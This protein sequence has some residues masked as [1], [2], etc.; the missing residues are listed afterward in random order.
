MTRRISG[1]RRRRNNHLR[2]LSRHSSNP[3]TIQ[4][5]RHRRQHKGNPHRPSHGTLNNR[6]KSARPIKS[7]RNINITP[8]QRSN[9]GRR[10]IINDRRAA[11]APQESNQRRK[12]RITSTTGLNTP[13]L[14][15]HERTRRTHTRKKQRGKPQRRGHRPKQR[16]GSRSSLTYRITSQERSTFKRHHRRIRHKYTRP[17]THR[18]QGSSSNTRIPEHRLTQSS[19]N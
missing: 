16:R 3:R 9:K 7:R 11:R 6:R 4:R 17:P 12:P 5:T 8:Q 15:G 1:H 10:T 14:R 2:R 18:R 13:C 19:R